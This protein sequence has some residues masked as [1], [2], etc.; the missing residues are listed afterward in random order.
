MSTPR[1]FRPVLD[2]DDLD[3]IEAALESTVENALDTATNIPKLA[4]EALLLR[5]KA[6]ELVQRFRRM[7]GRSITPGALAVVPGQASLDDAVNEA[8]VAESVADLVSVSEEDEGD[9]PIVSPGEGEEVV[10]A[11]FEE[12]GV[13]EEDDAV[14]KEDIGPDRL[15]DGTVIPSDEPVISPDVVEYAN[16]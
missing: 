10:E 7:R 11:L 6:G 15:D 4:H 5:A 3:L 16:L 2:S 8:V 13:I 9:E 1:Q 14:P 12:E